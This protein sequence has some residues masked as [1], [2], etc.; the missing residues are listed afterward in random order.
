MSKRIAKP[1]KP[2]APD[3]TRVLG[4]I[5]VSTDEQAD[6]GLSMEAQERAIRAYCDMRGLTLVGVVSDPGVSGGAP[7]AERPGG[8]RLVGAPGG[9]SAGGIGG[10]VATKLD[11]LFRDAADCLTV[12][13]DWD[14]TGVALHLIDVGGQSIDTS[15]AMGRFFLTVMAGAAE[16]ER[17]LVHERT[18]AALAQKRARGEKTGGHRPVG[19]DVLDGG[20]LTPNAAERATVARAA[21]LRAAG[22]SL[23]AI[24]AELV[25]EGR[26]PR[27]GAD[28][29][30]PKQVAD[31]LDAAAE[32]AA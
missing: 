12:V 20:K 4:Y 28:T 26:R 17:N 19:F 32:L 30:N 27:N 25:T 24:G 5:R 7:L 21:E 15:S 23:R 6:S 14:R 16:L 2:A 11:R 9:G 1:S 18:R 3:T 13:R 22:R 10:V 29:W 31:L 8:A